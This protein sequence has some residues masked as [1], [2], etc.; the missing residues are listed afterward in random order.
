MSHSPIIIVGAG[1][2]G[3]L[4][5]RDLA[6]AGRTVTV[7]EA[8]P[9]VGGRIHTAGGG[10]FSAPVEEGAE[11]I[12]GDAPLTKALLREAGVSWQDTGGRAYQL[13]DG[14]LAEAEEF[15]PDMPRLLAALHQLP[16]DMPLADFLQQYF[17]G[18]AD[19]AMR[20]QITRFAE[21]FDV[22]DPRR[23]STRGL[24]QE[25]EAGGAEDSPRPNG[26]YRQLVELLRRQAQAA[27]AAVHCEAPVAEIRW[28]AGQVEVHCPDGRTFRARQALITVPLGVLRL[29]P[30]EPG[31][32][33]FVPELPGVQAAA[34]ALGF[35]S[36]VKVLLEFDAPFW[37]ADTMPRPA[38]E[39]GFLFADAPFPTWWSALPDGRP[40]L[41][42]WLGGPPAEARRH[43]PVAELLT[44]ALR[45]LAGILGTTEA[46]LRP[47]LR[48]QRVVDWGADPWARGAY[49]YA[50]VGSEAARRLLLTPVADTLYFAGEALYA[51]PNSGTVE[52]AL[53][54]AAQVVRLLV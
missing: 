43:T 28:Q 8:R 47:R 54:S 7:L 50:T 39:L 20:E 15:I 33:G 41:T 31:Y 44:E 16:A 10:G 24:G 29:G 4:A 23:A 34:A 22:A 3:L 11:F 5:A 2:A 53:S 38:P 9:R 52:A 12:H 14:Q 32:L 25:W 19:A 42:G 45:S 27:G 17:P 37:E 46:A 40:L 21:G 18:P 6:R 51:G 48:A 49:S 35:G 36:V 13:R 1:V 26:G 30:A